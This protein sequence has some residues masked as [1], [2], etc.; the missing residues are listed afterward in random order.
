MKNPANDIYKWKI[1]KFQHQDWRLEPLYSTSITTLRCAKKQI[2]T[3]SRAG[4]FSSFILLL[5]ALFK[6]QDISMLL[7]S[8]SSIIS[9][10]REGNCK[11]VDNS[12]A[13]A[14]FISSDS[15]KPF[16]GPRLHRSAPC[17]ANASL[18]FLICNINTFYLQSEVNMIY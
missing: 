14:N 3:Y 16:A 2:K 8:K 4:S 7:M 10:F 17:F 18:N 12:P 1:E 13:D 5:S 6:I 15:S 9:S 11:F